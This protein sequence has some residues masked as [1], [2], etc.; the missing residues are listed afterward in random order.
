MMLPNLTDTFPTHAVKLRYVRSI[1][2]TLDDD[3]SELSLVSPLSLKGITHK[4]ISVI[5]H[6]LLVPVISTVAIRK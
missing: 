2:K 4:F 1:N 6:T 3:L 5:L